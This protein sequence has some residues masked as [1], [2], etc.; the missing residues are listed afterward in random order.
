[1]TCAAG[2]TLMFTCARQ[3]SAEMAGV[4]TTVGSHVADTGLA[5]SW[6]RLEGWVAKIRGLRREKKKKKSARRASTLASTLWP[7]RP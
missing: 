5:E 7:G 3:P 4:P 2:A 1:M 6:R